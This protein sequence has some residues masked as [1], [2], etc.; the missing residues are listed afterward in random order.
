VKEGTERLAELSPEAVQSRMF[1]VMWQASLRGSQR[2]PLV[3][4][5][6]DVHWI[7]KASET[8]LDSLVE[9]LAG[10]RILLVLTYRPGFGPRWLDKS[11][12]TQI[13]LQPLSPEDSLTVVS[14]LLPAPATP[15]PLAR[16]IVDKAEGNPFFLEELART[17]GEQGASGEAAVPD[18]IQEVVEARIHRLPDEPRRALQAAAILGREASVRLLRAL[19]EGPGDPE[20]HL[21]TLTRLEFLYDK[22]AGDEPVFVFKHALTREVARETLPP[23]RRQALHAA[24]GRAL[25]TFYA[26]RLE[27]VHDR[28]AYHYAKAK[29][30]DKAVLYLT[31]FAEKAAQTYAHVEAV[32]ALEEALDH[33][34]RLP[35][36]E[37]DAQQLELVLRQAHS[38]ALLGRFED[39][40]ALLRRAEPRL[41][42]LASATVAGPFY[43]WLAHTHSYLGDHEQAAVSAR[44]AIEAAT[45]ANDEGTLGKAHVMLAQEHYWAGQPIRGVA[46]GH[47][48]VE[49]LESAGERWWLG[50][51]HWVV[52]INYV[53]LGAFAHALA[54]QAEALAV[55]EALGDRRIQSYATWSTGWIHALA[56]AW[57][58]GIEACRRALRDAPDPVN[59]AVAE[60][61]LGYVYL[62]KGDAPEAAPLLERAVGRMREFRFRRLLGRFTTFLGEAYLLAG[63]REEARALVEEGLAISAEAR[64]G[65]GLGW[66]QHAL[67]RVALAAG[68]PAEADRHL[69]TARQTFAR[70]HARFMVG[71]TAL[72]QAEIAHTRSDPAATAA[73]LADAALIFGLL[74]VSRYLARTTRL[75]EAYGVSSPPAPGP[76]PLAGQRAIVRRG[77]EELFRA[78]E[79]HR[80]ALHV[81]SVMWDQRLGERR[82]GPRV[83]DADRRRR[84]RRGTP[85]PTWDTLGFLLAP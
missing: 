66:A 76:A 1:D 31:R 46:R 35:T 25:E 72:T 80:D 54:A 36:E 8:Y 9:S 23:A 85:G 68:D 20:P 77:D 49:L 24:A 69:A 43:F 12:A 6:E 63:R 71:R 58:A 17:V 51:A 15:G 70:I 19:W 45:Q 33:A 28:L 62:E 42:R 30:A 59:T 29:Q 26:D 22:P 82:S 81:G 40:L 16:R 32:A 75:A 37:R 4:A 13:A 74:G 53:I 64:Y 39:T 83:V 38:L 67:G 18:T 48:A 34:T 3:F 56:G 11:Y 27:T 50:L 61:H 78:L 14:A 73:Y 21:R 47:R 84:D 65:Y 10:A 60:G 7:D 52:G 55:G 5:I 57:E 79:V 44:R 2:R 41:Q